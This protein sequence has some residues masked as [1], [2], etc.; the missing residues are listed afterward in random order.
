MSDPARGEVWSVDLEPVRG[1]EQGGK[2][3]ALVLSADAFNQSL[4]D[5]VVVLPITSRPKGLRSHVPV[6]APEG[7]VRKPSFIKCEDIRSV[8]R[9]RLSRRW[10]AVSR[11]TMQAVEDR[12]RILLEL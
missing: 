5:L 6:V 12:V 10:G 9:E 2:R 3:P 11:Q 4:A 1:H 8:A 7:G